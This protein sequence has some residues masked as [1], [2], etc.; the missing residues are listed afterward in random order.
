MLLWLWI[1]GWDPGPKAGLPVW[2][3]R[4]CHCYS[5]QP[6]YWPLSSP[7]ATACLRP[8]RQLLGP[9][10]GQVISQLILPMLR[11]ESLSDCIVSV[12]SQAQL[13]LPWA[14]MFTQTGT[15]PSLMW[16]KQQKKHG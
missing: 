5:T 1:L 7:Q 4:N 10:L 16:G 9:S 14:G 12:V 13:Q 6:L 3:G 2:V 11:F 8:W 15:H